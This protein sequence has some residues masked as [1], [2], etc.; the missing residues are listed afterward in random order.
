MTTG[1]SDFSNLIGTDLTVS[2]D[3]VE[4]TREWSEA[5]ERREELLRERIRSGEFTV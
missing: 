4:S 5:D 2:W 3:A 1:D